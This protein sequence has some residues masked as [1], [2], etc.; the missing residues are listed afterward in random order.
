MRRCERVSV[1]GAW[2]AGLMVLSLAVETM[3]GEIAWIESYAD[4][5]KA[6]KKEKKPTMIDFYADWCGWCKK[7]DKD[8]YTDAAIIKA[9]E[10]FVCIKVDA[11]KNREL[12]NKS[13]VSGLPTIVFTDSQGKE[14]H[15]VVGYRPP[16]AFAEEMKKALGAAKGK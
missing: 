2:V 15:R 1:W 12:L 10:K 16:A 9:A 13:N 14:I 3:A 7:L 5:M 6:A 4:G 11:D 8:T